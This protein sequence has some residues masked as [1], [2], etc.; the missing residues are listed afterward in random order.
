[1]KF[2]FPFLFFYSEFCIHV[3]MLFL[4][5]MWWRTRVSQIH[6]TANPSEVCRPTTAVVGYWISWTCPCSISSWETWTVTITRRSPFSATTRF[7]FT[8]TTA[9]RSANRFTT[10]S[11][12]WRQSCSAVTYGSPRSKFCSGIG[13]W[14]LLYIKYNILYW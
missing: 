14:L 1:M 3:L 5:R 10:S 2:L 11:A 6:I 13:H 8:S 7:P 9:G 12:Y 4:L